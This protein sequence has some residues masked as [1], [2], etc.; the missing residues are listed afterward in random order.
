M[1]L[2]KAIAYLSHGSDKYPLGHHA[3]YSS[4]LDCFNTGV[5]NLALYSVR[6]KSISMKIA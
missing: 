5:A 3:L 4:I 1:M 6:Y 2:E